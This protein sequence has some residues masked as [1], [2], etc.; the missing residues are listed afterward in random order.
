MGR[1]QGPSVGT[2]TLAWQTVSVGRHRAG[3]RCDV[4][5]TNDLLQ[6]WI[7]TE[8]MR[9][10]PRNGTGT[11]RNNNAQGGATTKTRKPQ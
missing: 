9:T 1:P 8:L 3:D 5:V 4:H 10:V 6:F 11:I 2:V 7:G